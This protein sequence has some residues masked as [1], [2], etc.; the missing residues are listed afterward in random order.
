MALGSPTS[1]RLGG[2]E[3][4]VFFVT[5]GKELELLLLG[6]LGG[7]VEHLLRQVS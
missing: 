1:E 2:V 6:D 5:V 4:V 7:L 3:V